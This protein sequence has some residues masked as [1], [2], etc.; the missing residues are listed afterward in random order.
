MY[1]HFHQRTKPYL[2]LTSGDL[3][4]IHKIHVPKRDDLLFFKLHCFVNIVF[5]MFVSVLNKD[6]NY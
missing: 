6:Y 3:F 4:Y 5:N 2:A 1:A